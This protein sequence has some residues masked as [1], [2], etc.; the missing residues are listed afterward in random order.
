MPKK[1]VKIIQS[2]FR[3]KGEL[4]SEENEISR[5]RIEGGI[6][7]YQTVVPMGLIFA[8]CRPPADVSPHLKPLTPHRLPLT[9][10]S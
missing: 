4:L 5:G 10:F 2:L 9:L 8:G 7:F 1:I 3:A 6:R